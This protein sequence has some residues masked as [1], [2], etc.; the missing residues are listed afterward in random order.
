MGNVMNPE[1]LKG[2]S[3]L[4]KDRKVLIV[5]H[6]NPDPD[7][8]AAA[9]ALSFFLKKACGV[10]SVI[11]YGGLITRAEN[12]SM[13]ER[14]RIPLKPIEKVDFELFGG[15]ALVDTQPSFR[16]HSLPPCIEPM[17]VID[18]HSSGQKG[19]R[20]GFTDIRP[21]YGSTSTILTEYLIQANLF[22]AWKVAT[23][24]Y[25]GIRSDTLDLG[26]RATEADIKATVALYPHVN[27][28]TIAGIVH[29]NL[30]REYVIDYDR[31]L[32]GAKIYGDVILADL[33]YL[34]NT[35]MVAMMADFFL[36]VS[37]IRWSLVMARDGKHLVFSLRTKR[38]KQNAGR[39][40]QRLVKGWGAAGGHGQVAGGQ[41]PL[42]Q[43]PSEKGETLSLV[44]TRRFLKAVGREGSHE[45]NLL[46][47]A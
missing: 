10:D 11:A 23:A 24:L 5:P 16:N 25:Y 28:K 41:I 39:I 12:R 40:A 21:N 13:V 2:L 32:H 38:L 22:K 45:E 46:P 26:R 8:I 30:S 14:L 37:D 34:K 19:T 33:G 18:H 31:A 9:F 35:E 27:L 44:L 47:P 4:L 3:S 20:V 43:F 1:A 15:F 36:R 7:A 17:V 42:D 6:N 29:P